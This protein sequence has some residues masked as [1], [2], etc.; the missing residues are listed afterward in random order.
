MSLEHKYHTE[1]LLFTVVRAFE[2]GSV[3][4]KLALQAQPTLQHLNDISRTMDQPGF[5]QFGLAN[6]AMDV[7]ETDVG[8]DPL[9]QLR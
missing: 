8:L 9:S 6:A 4:V 5:N 1:P 2:P 7:L 3:M